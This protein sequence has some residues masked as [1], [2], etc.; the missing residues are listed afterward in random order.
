MA[1]T[2]PGGESVSRG[3]LDGDD[4]KRSGMAITVSDD[5]DT[6]NIATTSDH[7]EIS[8]VQLDVIGDLSGVDIND[9]GV[10]SLESNHCENL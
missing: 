4:V 1:L 5:S 9:N 7:A 10:I 2:L 3:V 6:A 8:G